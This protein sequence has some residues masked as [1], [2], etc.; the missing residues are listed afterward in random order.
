LLVLKF[1][2]ARHPDETQPLA[3]YA[4]HGLE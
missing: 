2:P 1:R 4:D 3:S